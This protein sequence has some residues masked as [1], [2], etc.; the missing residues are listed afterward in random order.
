MKVKIGICALVLTLA[1]PALAQASHYVDGYTRRDGTYVQPHMQTNPNGNAFD[2][3]S[4]KPNVNPYT[5]QQGTRDPYTVPESG[6][7]NPG[8]N[9][10]SY[11]H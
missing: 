2:N 7:Y 3:W 4:S 10:G 5:G 8:Y 9:D 1:G 11:D 6:R